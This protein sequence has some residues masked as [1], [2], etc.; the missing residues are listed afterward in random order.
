MGIILTNLK[1]VFLI[2]DLLG[3]YFFLFKTV[4]E[5][6]CCAKQIKNYF[7]KDIFGFFLFYLCQLH[8]PDSGL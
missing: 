7:Q 8:F 1:A 5:V 3:N 2:S 6:N 4:T